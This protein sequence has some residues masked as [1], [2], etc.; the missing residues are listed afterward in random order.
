MAERNTC[1]LKAAESRE[2]QAVS[3]RHKSAKKK[4]DQPLVKDLKSCYCCGGQHKAEV[5]Q[6][7]TEKCRK[8]GKVG[9]MAK[10]CRS[11]EMT[12]KV[13]QPEDTLHLNG[14]HAVTIDTPKL[15]EL[16][17]SLIVAMR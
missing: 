5:C 4:V 12:H 11:R 8:C 16:V 2:V 13:K 9:H 1:E 7:Q 3:D 14:I 17:N 15:G 10:K 6:Y